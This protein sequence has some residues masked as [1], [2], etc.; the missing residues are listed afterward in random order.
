VG[1]ILGK[2]TVDEPEGPR[3]P[4]LMHR[5]DVPGAWFEEGAGIEIEMPRRL[6][7]ARCEG[8]GCDVCGRAGAFVLRGPEDV[9]EKLSVTLPRAPENGVVI[10]KIPEAGAPLEAGPLT[11]EAPASLEAP[12]VT[13][14]EVE[15]AEPLPPEP[16][17]P[18]RAGRGMLFLRVGMAEAASPGVRRTYGVAS[19]AALSDAERR[20][21]M[22]RS[23]LLVGGLL[24]VFLV[25]LWL[26]GW[27]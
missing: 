21:L 22:L 25:M 6:A 23:G 20:K 7:C 11:D 2:I 8:G 4:D 16:E 18:A 13:P 19:A 5:I 14:A 24:V 26:S 3:G 10:L 1:Q 17:P 9:P 27:L 12:A 15:V